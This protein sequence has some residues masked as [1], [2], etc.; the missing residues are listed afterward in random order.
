MCP[1]SALIVV[2]KVLHDL[3]Q[4]VNNLHGIH[5][6]DNK[7][8]YRTIDWAYQEEETVFVFVVLD[9]SDWRLFV[10]AND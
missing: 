1:V 9:K 7:S 2:I 6:S 8:N 3:P 5:S 10:F 4:R